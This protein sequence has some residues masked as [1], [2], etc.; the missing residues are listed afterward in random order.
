M[1]LNREQAEKL[2]VCVGCQ[3]QLDEG[4]VEALI[5]GRRSP[6]EIACEACHEG[7]EH[8]EY[9]M[10]LL[11]KIKSAEMVAE[12]IVEAGLGQEYAEEA[13]ARELERE[14]RRRGENN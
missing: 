1:K 14:L 8:A 5:S 6:S 4:A 2:A 10:Y 13:R 12:R 11:A 3:R 7:G 9:V